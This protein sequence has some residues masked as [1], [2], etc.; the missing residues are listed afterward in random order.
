VDDYMAK[1]VK[2]LAMRTLDAHKIAYQVYLFPDTIHSAVEVATYID[3]PP[4]QVFK[5][6]VVLR[7]GDT[8][9]RPLLVIVPGNHEID[10][11]HLARELDVK[12]VRMAGHDQAEKLTG[13]K[14]GGISSLALLHRPFDIYLD[15]SAQ[16]FDEIAMSA[17][18]RG[19]NLQLSVTD[20]LNLTHARLISAL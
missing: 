18:Q 3:M 17:G 16:N 20:F 4:E 8:R 1:K 12:S 9:A 19:V 7:E 14:V 15:K 13:L 11:R 2:T 10:L 5:T 6:L